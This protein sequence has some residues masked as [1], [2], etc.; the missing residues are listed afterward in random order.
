MLASAEPGSPVPQVAGS[1]AV[2]GRTVQQYLKDVGLLFAAPFLTL[3]WLALFPL[4]G[5][6]VLLRGVRQASSR[7]KPAG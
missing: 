1:D 5:L 6:M 3:A 7:H 4:I 2:Q